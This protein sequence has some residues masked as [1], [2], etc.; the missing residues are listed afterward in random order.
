MNKKFTRSI[1]IGLVIVLAM[2][3][4]AIAVF[5]QEDTLP[6][7]DSVPALPFAGRGGFGGPR[8]HHDGRADEEALAEA[9]GISVEELQAARDQLQAERLAQAVEDGYLTQEEADNMQ[10][11]HALKA[12][13]DREVILAEALGLTVEEVEAARA[14]GSLADILS[15]ITPAD[16]QAQ[17][18]AAMETAVDAAVADGVIT[19]EQA[20]LALQQLADGAG[21]MGKFGG[22]PGPRGGFRGFDGVQPEL[23]GAAFAPIDA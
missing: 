9:L 12:Y 15:N 23:D 2:A 21:R 8:G 11:M 10:A 14:D 18:Q 19:Q 5:A 6:D 3:L 22:H 13:I 17:M 20:G 16:L 7:T 4:G 1:V